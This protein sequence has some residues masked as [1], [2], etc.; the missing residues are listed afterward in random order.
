M[1]AQIGYFD[2]LKSAAGKV[3]S[4]LASIT[5]TG[6]DGKTLTLNKTLTL[7]APDDTAV[8]TLPAGAHSLAPLD[9]PTFTAGIGVG[10][11]AAGTGGV[12]FPAA[13]VAV[14]DVNTLDDYEEGPWFPSVGGTATYDVANGGTYTKIGRQVTII[15]QLWITAIGTGATSVVSGLPFPVAAGQSPAFSIGYWANLAVS[16]IYFGGYC[17]PS[18]STLNFTG[19]VTSGVTCD[20]GINCLGDG[21]RININAT[22]FT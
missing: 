7:T 10:N 22:Y 1:V 15:G 8:A 9:S 6:T 21:T 17:I 2:T 12:A 20:N 18:S 13:E 16:T 14:A 5:L 4:Y 19:K 11:V 3:F